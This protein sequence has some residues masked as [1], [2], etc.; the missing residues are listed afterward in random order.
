M[1]ILLCKPRELLEK[2]KIDKEHED[3]VAS[4]FADSC[5]IQVIAVSL[6]ARET[7]SYLV[8]NN[9]FSYVEKF[10]NLKYFIFLFLFL[11]VFAVYWIKNS[12]AVM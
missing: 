7:L 1:F 9:V 8:Q 12:N 2:I 11:K 5:F 4:A 3:Y 10:Q 6:R